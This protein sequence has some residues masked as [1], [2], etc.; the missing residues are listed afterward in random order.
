MN[1]PRVQVHDLIRILS[2]VNARSG[3][4]CELHSPFSRSCEKGAV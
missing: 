1:G 3:V 4:P 2:F